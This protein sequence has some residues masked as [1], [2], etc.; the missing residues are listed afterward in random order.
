AQNGSQREL[1]GRVQRRSGETRA[2]VAVGRRPHQQSPLPPPTL[3]PLAAIDHM[4]ERLRANAASFPALMF[5]AEVAGD[6]FLIDVT[7]QQRS[8]LRAGRPVDKPET[9]PKGKSWPVFMTFTRGRQ[10]DPK[11]LFRGGAL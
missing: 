2:E 10:Q 11:P 7:E 8:Q 9:A 4:I 1:S 5:D 3:L 6:V